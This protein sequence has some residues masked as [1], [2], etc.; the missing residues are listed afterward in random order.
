MVEILSLP[1]GR[2]KERKKRQ[3]PHSFGGGGDHPA[4]RRVGSGRVT[5][6]SAPAKRYEDLARMSRD[7]RARPS[8]TVTGK[9]SSSSSLARTRR[10]G[11]GLSRLVQNRYLRL[12]RRSAVGCNAASLP[13][14]ACVVYVYV[15]V[16]ARARARKRVY[17]LVRVCVA[18]SRAT[19]NASRTVKDAPSEIHAAYFTESQSRNARTR[20]K[21][22]PMKRIQ[23]G[24]TALR[25]RSRFAG[26][27][28]ERQ[29]LIVASTVR[30]RTREKEKKK[31][32]MAARLLLS[33]HGAARRSDAFGRAAKSTERAN[34]PSV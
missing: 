25:D 14:R 17:V 2:V 19:E 9:S 30:E 28:R 8:P 31:R 11:G 6:S 24:K 26:W 22:E 15:Y 13:P 32:E 29:F 21:N 1:R 3:S 34:S 27:E 33:P 16:R 12:D 4:N 5:S 18:H 20:D 10:I 7:R 23:G